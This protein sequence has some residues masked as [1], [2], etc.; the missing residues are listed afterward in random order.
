MSVFVW[1]LLQVYQV[2]YENPTRLFLATSEYF[3]CSAHGLFRVSCEVALTPGAGITQF[4]TACYLSLGST[5]AYRLWNSHFDGVKFQ[6]QQDYTITKKTFIEGTE[7]KTK[8]TLLNDSCWYFLQEESEL[9]KKPFASSMSEKNIFSKS[10]DHVSCHNV[11]FFSP[12]GAPS[13]NCCYVRTE[14]LGCKQAYLIRCHIPS[15]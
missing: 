7:E 12:L 5:F 4:S 10:S 13:L 11:N 8:K 9:V 1:P 15:Q 14:H 3:S 6:W 2:N